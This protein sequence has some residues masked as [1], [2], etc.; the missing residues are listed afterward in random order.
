MLPKGVRDVVVKELNRRL[1]LDIDE[2]L[3]SPKLELKLSPAEL[4]KQCLEL[5][6]SVSSGPGG[7]ILRIIGG[8]NDVALQYRYMK[9]QARKQLKAA[10]ALNFTLPFFVGGSV[11]NTDENSR[12]ASQWV[13]WTM[14]RNLPTNGTMPI[15]PP[16]LQGA[17]EDNASKKTAASSQKETENNLRMSLLRPSA[18]TSGLDSWSS[19]RGS[20]WTGMGV[21][22]PSRLI[23]NARMLSSRRSGKGL[24]LLI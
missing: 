16:T 12:S 5:F 10:N 13:R 23:T 3:N 22:H 8:G 11:D 17:V 7:D 2:L 18:L 6:E 9:R 14:R 24:S 15:Y 20:S 21:P 4:D 1:D 19:R